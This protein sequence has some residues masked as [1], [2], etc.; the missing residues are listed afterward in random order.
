MHNTILQVSC[1]FKQ[2]SYNHLD[3]IAVRT[4]AGICA[5]LPH[6]TNSATHA[7]LQ[8]VHVHVHQ[9]QCPPAISAIDQRVSSTA[10]HLNTV[11]ASSRSSSITC[12]VHPHTISTRWLATTTGPH[13]SHKHPM[14]KHTLLILRPADFPPSIHITA[15]SCAMLG[16]A[17]CCRSTCF[18]RVWLMSRSNHAPMS[19]TWTKYSSWENNAHVRGSPSG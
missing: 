13:G 17:T 11:C 10:E 14:H 8:V 6:C 2:W 9:H 15:F 7:C 19:W 18:S 5:T 1:S 16:G 12:A 3:A 4:S